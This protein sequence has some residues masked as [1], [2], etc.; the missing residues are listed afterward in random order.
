MDQ[1]LKNY[2]SGMQVRLAFSIAIRAESD[3]LVLDEVLAVGDTNFQ[4]KC[5]DYFERIKNANKTIILVTHD[6]TA[7][8]RFCDKAIVIDN[9][10]L[11]YRGNPAE[12]T[13]TYSD[14]S[15][16]AQAGLLNIKTSKNKP[17]EPVTIRASIMGQY[18]PTHTITD[19]DKKIT[20]SCDIESKLN[21]P[22]AVFGVIISNG[23]GAPIF[24][25]NTK[26]SKKDLSIKKGT[27]M[28]LQLEIEN[29]FSNGEYTVSTGI[30]NHDQTKVYYANSN[31]TKFV[32]GGRKHD[33][34]LV[35]PEYTIK[36]K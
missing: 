1:K 16:A 32:V 12:A 20:L 8:E 5:S 9:G 25:T 6:M 19:K 11:L 23:S 21:V 29:I 10:K 2:S 28:N 36:T 18:G 24:A 26:V 3:I 34:A 14:L 30:K 7:V 27:P 4:K 31:T 17:D 15:V 22:K 33:F 35:N 13:K